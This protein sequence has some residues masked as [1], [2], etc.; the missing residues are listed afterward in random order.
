MTFSIE[1]FLRKEIDKSG[2]F[3]NSH[4]HLDR[5]YTL[6]QDDFNLTNNDLKVKWNLVRDLK[7]K[8]TTNQ[9]TAN[10]LS[11]LTYQK[12]LGVK[13][14]CTFLD[15][16]E[17]SKDKPF[18]AYLKAKENMGR[19]I[20][21]K[22]VNQTLTGVL[23][24]QARYWFDMGSSV[25]DIIG[26]LPSID[27]CIENHLDIVLSRGKKLNKKVHIHVDQFNT[28][29]EDETSLVLDKII[30]YGMEGQVV[31]I[32]GI[33][34]SAKPKEERYSIYKKLEQTNTSVICCPNAWLDSRR[35]E[36]LQPSHNSIT[37]IDE[38][39]DFN[40]KIGLGTDN[41][42]DLMCPFINGDMFDELKTLAVGLR[43]Y[44][45]EALI[46]IASGG[47]DIIWN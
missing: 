30:Q 31:L 26:S 46:K 36:E 27:K 8:L 22:S 10:M 44:N 12:M 7:S 14:I 29:K 33:S 13:G 2:G 17:T 4:C 16:D 32:H 1:G 19:L 40:I 41:I 9:I 35:S 38:M 15:F 18:Q 11:A 43:L 25:C 37:P 3:Y 42:S 20:K 21:L 5:A 34:I 39:L 45:T 28:N 47:N 6:N 23:E 24:P